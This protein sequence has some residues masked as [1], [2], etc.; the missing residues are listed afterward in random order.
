MNA[1][2]EIRGF[3]LEDY[4]IGESEE[5]LDNNDSFLEKGIIDSTGILE[6]IMFIEEIYNIEVADEEVIPDNLDSVNKVCI[7]IDRKISKMVTI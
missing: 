4:M 5:A 1:K 3:I 6:L 2:N 7:Y